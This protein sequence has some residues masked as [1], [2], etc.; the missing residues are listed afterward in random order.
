MAPTQ[1]KDL[2]VKAERVTGWLLVIRSDS[3]GCEM[4]G[5]H[6]QTPGGEREVYVPARWPTGG[7]V[8][9]VSSWVYRSAA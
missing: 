5:V 8:D 3:L 7:A 4:K 1:W 2:E 9:G 6:S